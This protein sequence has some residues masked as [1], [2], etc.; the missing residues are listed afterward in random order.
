MTLNLIFELLNFK[1]PIRFGNF[2]IYSA[3]SLSLTPSVLE[4]RSALTCRCSISFFLVST[5]ASNGE[6]KITHE[7][8]KD[9][10]VFTFISMFGSIVYKML[11]SLVW[12]EE[13]IFLSARTFRSPVLLRWE[14]DVGIEMGRRNCG[15]S[16]FMIWTRI[17]LET[18][19]TTVIHINSY[20][21]YFSFVDALWIDSKGNCHEARTKMQK[22]NHAY[23][24]FKWIIFINGWMS[25]VL[26]CRSI[27]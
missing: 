22:N 17:W 6:M 2:Y 3:K 24:A 4:S 21:C 15:N 7:A 9:F 16:V 10:V 12:I 5:V 18:T 23:E 8:L 13:L 26:Q 20:S 27:W 1:L 11:S 19:L 25:A 14:N